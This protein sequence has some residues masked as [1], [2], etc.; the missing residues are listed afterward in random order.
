MK[1]SPKGTGTLLTLITNLQANLT[2]LSIYEFSE[3]D[4]KEITKKL[5]RYLNLYE[6]VTTE[7]ELL[8]V[9][10]VEIV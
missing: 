3:D 7:E 6:K 10:E 5:K 1:Y 2:E 8:Q 9:I 4:I